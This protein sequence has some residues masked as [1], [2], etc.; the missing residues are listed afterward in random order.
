MSQ[1]GLNSPSV[2]VSGSN[3]TT[4]ISTTYIYASSAGVISSSGNSVMATF[5]DPFLPLTMS[6][7]NAFSAA[8]KSGSC[9]LGSLTTSLAGASSSQAVTQLSATGCADASVITVSLDTSKFSDSL[10]QSGTTIVTTDVTVDLA[11]TVS[12][13]A[14]GNTLA[15][16]AGTSESSAGYFAMGSSADASLVMTFS[17][18]MGIFAATLSGTGC[19]ATLGTGVIVGGDRKVIAWPVTGFSGMASGSTCT[20]NVANAK[21]VVGNYVDSSDANKTMTITFH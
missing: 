16:G 15:S 11:P 10:K 4:Y 5:S 6:G 18:N 17:K 9:T 20:L 12:V 3:I 21:D 1:S 19:S 7:T 2:S 8:M 14:T 13:V